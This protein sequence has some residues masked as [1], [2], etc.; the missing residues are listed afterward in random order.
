MNAKSNF[1]RRDPAEVEPWRET[2]GQIRCLI[3]EKDGAAAKAGL[4]GETPSLLNLDPKHGDLSVGIDFRQVYTSILED[5]LSLP[6]RMA[7]G[8]SFS[9]LPLF[10]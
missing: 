1:L 4:V 6:A 3:E 7:L 2:C 10:R 8:A 5:W 9:G